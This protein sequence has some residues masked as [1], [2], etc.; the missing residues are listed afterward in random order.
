MKSPALIEEQTIPCEAC[1][2]CL[3]TA[4][5]LLR[6]DCT[7]TGPPPSIHP[8]PYLSP[9]PPPSI[10]PS[11]SSSPSKEPSHQQYA[12][13]LSL[14]LPPACIVEKSEI[15]S[16]FHSPA[17]LKVEASDSESCPP[18]LKHEASDPDL[19]PIMIAFRSYVMSPDELASR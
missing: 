4:K 2:P 13:T 8:S 10:H 9:N 11:P 19:H 3:S 7:C 1:Y 15:K 14:F 18:I 6:G 17:T 16:L 5:K 12:R